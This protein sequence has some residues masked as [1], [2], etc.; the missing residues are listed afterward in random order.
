M[1]NIYV[2]FEK[3]VQEGLN[4]FKHKFYAFNDS[5]FAKGMAEIGLEADKDNDKIYSIGG[6][7]YVAKKHIKEFEDI[8]SSHNAKR[9]ELMKDDK[10]VMDMFSYELANHEYCITYDYEPTL[11]A[12]GL[13]LQDVGNDL[14]LKKLLSKAE[15]EY[16]K[17]CDY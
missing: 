1:K 11:A 3:E 9:R 6:G 15:K 13:D 10:F 8:F 5:Q 16:L 7:C 2:E 4:N 12:C 14:R 17:G